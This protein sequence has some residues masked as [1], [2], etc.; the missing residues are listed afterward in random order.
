MTD[1]GAWPGRR[2]VDSGRWDARFWEKSNGFGP[3]ATGGLP[4]WRGGSGQ[5]IR[6]IAKIEGHQNRTGC[7][8]S[9]S[10]SV[11]RSCYPR[12]VRSPVKIVISICWDCSGQRKAIDAPDVKASSCRHGDPEY[13]GLGDQ[14]R[15]NASIGLVLEPQIAALNKE[16]LGAT[17][18]TQAKDRLSLDARTSSARGPGC[19]SAEAIRI[20]VRP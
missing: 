15:R 16:P 2:T 1:S 9:A 11:K 8:W 19:Q 17:D 4:D 10:D 14:E 12:C 6:S 13:V 5:R 3:R 20:L 7:V 18:G